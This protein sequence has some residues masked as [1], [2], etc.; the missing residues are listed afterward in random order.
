[1]VKSDSYYTAG[2]HQQF[3]MVSFLVSR[4][5]THSAGNHKQPNEQVSFIEIIFTQLKSTLLHK[6]ILISSPFGTS[7]KETALEG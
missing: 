5:H 2:L 3:S 6:M 4:Y 1:M 7:G